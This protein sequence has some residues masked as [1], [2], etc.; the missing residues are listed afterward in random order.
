MSLLELKEKTRNAFSHA[1]YQIIDDEPIVV[2]TWCRCAYIGNDLWDVWLCN[3]L[4]LRSGLSQ[5]RIN[6]IRSRIAEISRRPGPYRELTGEGIYLAMPTDIF[7]RS[8]LALGIPKR[9]AVSP[10][11]GMRFT[12]QTAEAGQIG[13]LQSIET[14]S[15]GEVCS[16]T[17]NTEGEG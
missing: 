13:H 11:S 2:G 5:R 16:V 4:D 8:R 9:R 10:L 12:K 17:G 7:L 14:I 3:P 15:E 1:A 6:S